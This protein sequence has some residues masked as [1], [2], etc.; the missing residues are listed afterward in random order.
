MTARPMLTSGYRSTV[1][2]RFGDVRAVLAIIRAN[3]AVIFRYP[4]FWVLISVSMLHFLVTF[5][6]IYMKN[7]LAA[8][9][10]FSFAARLFDEIEVTGSGKAYLG[11]LVRQ[12]ESVYIMLAYASAVLLATDFQAGGINFYLSRPIGRVHYLLG[13]LGTLAI[14]VAIQTWLPA[15]GLFVEAALYASDF[16]YVREHTTI[17]V[18]ITG[19]S[20]LLMIV[21]SLLGLT[22]AILFRKTA[23]IVVVWIGLLFVLPAFGALLS[24]IFSSGHFLMIGLRYDLRVLGGSLFGLV[25]RAGEARFPYILIIVLS[26]SMICLAI[27]LRRLRPVEVVT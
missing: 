10:S 3:L 18:G 13:K 4:F 7:Q 17:L 8:E 1:R 25:S 22:I 16:E 11:F 14:L 5:A 15:I 9:Q 24:L 2:G 12:T 6:L 27:I 21:P 26:L 20:L 19:Y 23:A